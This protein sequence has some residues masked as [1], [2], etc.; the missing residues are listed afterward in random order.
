VAAW[1]TAAISAHAISG[2]NSIEGAAKMAY[3]SISENK[4]SARRRRNKR[5]LMAKI[6]RGI[7]N[8]GGGANE[9]ALAK[10]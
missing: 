10:A 6:S 5:Q 9:I 4:R 2:A 3:E 8:I 1:R 7:N